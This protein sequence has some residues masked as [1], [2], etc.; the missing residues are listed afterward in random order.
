MVNAGGISVKLSC[1]MA[2]DSAG[3]DGV[4]VCSGGDNDG[5]SCESL[6]DLG[7]D[8]CFGGANDG[9]A[10]ERTGDCPDGECANADC[11]VGG[12]C[13]PTDLASYTPDS[14]LIRYLI[15]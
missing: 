14:A 6:A 8:I 7:N 2:V 3:P 12:E 4:A 15:P 11:G 13:E 1:V 5:A 10:C 9:N